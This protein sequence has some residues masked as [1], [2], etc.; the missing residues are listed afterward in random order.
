[1]QQLLDF[2]WHHDIIL[3][4]AG[5]PPLHTPIR[6][7]S[8]LDAD[9][10]ARLDPALGQAGLSGTV[11]LVQARVRVVHVDS[12]T[13]DGLPPDSGLIRATEGVQN[14]LVLDVE[15][16]VRSILCVWCECGCVCV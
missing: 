9:I 8:E 6:V 7:L 14:T 2:P 3:H 16:P 12:K 13:M 4:E 15:R 5:V 10:K 11:A 1:M